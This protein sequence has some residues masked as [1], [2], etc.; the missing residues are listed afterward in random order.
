MVEEVTRGHLLSSPKVISRD[1][2][3]LTENF[4]KFMF[5]IIAMVIYLGVT[6][7]Y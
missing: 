2:G 4:D 6:N 3:D 5:G 1:K 7:G